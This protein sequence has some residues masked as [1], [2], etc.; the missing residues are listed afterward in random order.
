MK[1]MTGSVIW[2]YLLPLIQSDAYLM[3]EIMLQ[4]FF[5]LININKQNF[6][7]VVLRSIEIHFSSD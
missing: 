2:E 6:T 3:E 7:D 1:Y 5:D 4:F